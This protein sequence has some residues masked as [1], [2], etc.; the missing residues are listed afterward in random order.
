MIHPVHQERAL[1]KECTSGVSM[2]H[3]VAR[4][5]LCTRSVDY[6]PCTSGVSII[7]PVHQEFELYTLYQECALYTLYI[8]S[9]HDTHP[10]HQERALYKE[11]TLHTCIA[12]TPG[13][14]IIYPNLYTRSVQYMPCTRRIYCIHA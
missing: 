1:Y 7:Y 4:H 13:V 2:I 6:I 5:T 3:P 8:R 14:C 9:E 11:C 12:C 10:V